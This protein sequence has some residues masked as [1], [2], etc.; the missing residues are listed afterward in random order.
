MRLWSLTLALLLGF[1]AFAQDAEGPPK[2]PPPVA[3]D[4]EGLPKPPPRM[5]VDDKPTHYACTFDRLLHGQR[6]TYEFDPK[7]GTRS[8]SVARD[9]SQ[10]AAVAARLCPAAATPQYEH[11]PDAVL[12]KMCEDDV[13]RV[14]LD[15]C[16][17]DGR[18]PIQDAQGH[19]A[20][21]AQE[22]VESLGHVLARTQTMAGFSLPCC[23]CLSEA[24]CSVAAAQ[25]NKEMVDLAPSED[26]QSCLDNSC[27][28][29][30]SAA[31]PSDPLPA[32]PPLP[33]PLPP[34]PPQKR[35]RKA[36]EE[37][38]LKI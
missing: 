35:A 10:A 7:A 17:L 32:L 16:S 12:R 26:L 33:P 21:E 13:A 27:K 24:S 20:S 36:K 31:Q 22:C 14:S 5:P 11:R 23:R 25:C 19:V 15:G 2:P 38:A 3:A 4:D 1:S 34:P 18:I 29:A 9:N 30:C 8:D 37:P 6:C 28:N